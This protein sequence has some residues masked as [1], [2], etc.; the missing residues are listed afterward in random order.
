MLESSL[1]KWES[2]SRSRQMAYERVR[3][4]RKEAGWAWPKELAPL[5]GN[6]KAAA[7]PAGVRAF[8]DREIEQLGER[9]QASTKLQCADLVAWDCL[10]VFGLRPQEL[11]DLDLFA[12]PSG[13]AVSVVSRSKVS[14]KG[15]TK[16]NQ[17]LA[18]PPAGWP[19]DCHGLL[20]RWRD[21]GLP[22]WS[23]KTAS[24]GER[25]TKQLRRICM[26]GS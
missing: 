10:V 19:R 26:L 18:V 4:L 7:D 17:V 16:P 23:Q 6:G 9:I 5:R 15:K 14:S 20:A 8:G 21:H 22:D 24:P 11:V 12:G 25:M 2:K 1:R 13:V 3:W